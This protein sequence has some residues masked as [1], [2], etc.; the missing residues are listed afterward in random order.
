M[1]PMNN[2]DRTWKLPNETLEKLKLLRDNI[3]TNPYKKFYDAL[4]TLHESKN[5]TDLKEFIIELD[6]NS[7]DITFRSF[8]NPVKNNKGLLDSFKTKIHPVRFYLAALA[9]GSGRGICHNNEGA[10]RCYNYTISAINYFVRDKHEESEFLNGFKQ[11]VLTDFRDYIKS[12]NENQKPTIEEAISLAAMYIELAKQDHNQNKLGDLRLAFD[13][14]KQS[15]QTADTHTDTMRKFMY[16]IMTILLIE[17]KELNQ[18]NFFNETK[19]IIA[20]FITDDPAYMTKYLESYKPL[21]GFL[22]DEFNY[23]PGIWI[24]PVSKIKLKGNDSFVN[25][26][27]GNVI[28]VIYA[29]RG[30]S[31]KLSFTGANEH[32]EQAKQNLLEVISHSK[33]TMNEK[34]KTLTLLLLAMHNN[35]DN[36]TVTT[37]YY[38]KAC[39]LK[40]PIIEVLEQISTDNLYNKGDTARYLLSL[41]QSDVTNIDQSSENKTSHSTDISEETSTQVDKESYKS[42]YPSLPGPEKQMQQKP[43][44]TFLLFGSHQLI[45]THSAAALPILPTPPTNP[46]P[47]SPYGLWVEV[48]KLYETQ[49]PSFDDNYIPQYENASAP[50]QPEDEIAQLKLKNAELNE[51]LNVVI[52]K[53]QELRTKEENLLKLTSL[54]RKN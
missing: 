23:L 45:P 37:S 41:M 31:A 1:L 48:E 46:P 35:L 13:T 12:M 30:T 8:C 15:I 34:D 7:N 50:L 4:V 16:G 49:K 9:F 11:H 3:N 40:L 52:K 22:K 5:Q 25:A 53:S 32:Q 26:Y 6:K 54:R 47:Y 38:Q 19:K 39:E 21:F 17:K 20:D 33:N 36:D 29:N 43:V 42:I 10:I 51:K 14:I 18:T 2:K 44:C 24:E 27:T 28:N